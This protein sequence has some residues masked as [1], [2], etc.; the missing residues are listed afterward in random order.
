MRCKPVVSMVLCAIFSFILGGCGSTASQ[1]TSATQSP[2][3]GGSNAG[4]APSGGTQLGGSSSG[5]FGGSAGG[6]GATSGSGSGG[7]G[8]GSGGGTTPGWAE[9]KS[10]LSFAGQVLT[11]DFNHD[12]RPD[13]L[14]YG[15]GLS[16]LLN[17]G[18]GSF[19]AAINSSLPSGATTIAQ[20]ALADL[21]GDGFTDVAACTVGS[22]GTTGSASVYLND[23]SGKL[24]LGQVIALPAPCKGIAA[25]DA[26]HD[27][28]ADL[29][30]AYYTGSYSAPANA[31]A[32]WF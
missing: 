12:G 6:S 14:V 18:S 2:A 13:L 17:N 27:G 1:S 23:H 8:S 20:V 21:N 26:N 5:N 32:T 7:S 22:N 24:V 25:G 16:V 3:P 10:S 11:G 30:V 28:K 9:S 29:S 15:A 31:V 4:S 19:G